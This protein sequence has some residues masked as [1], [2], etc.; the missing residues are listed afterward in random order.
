MTNDSTQAAHLTEA[1]AFWDREITEQFYKGWL[2]N[3]PIRIYANTLIGGDRPLWPIPWFEEW[4]GG[5]TFERGL[6]IGC[7]SG[8][9]ERGFVE[10]GLC[11]RVDAFDASVA[12]LHLARTAAAEA[13]LGDRLRYFAANFNQPVFRAKYDI[14]LFHQ[15]AHHVAKL[16]RL[17]RAVL[18]ALKPDGLVYMDE[19]VGPSRHEWS[20]EGFARHRAIY[21]SLPANVREVDVLPYP[22][23]VD[24]PSEAIRS[25]EIETQL[26]VGFR[27]VARRPYGGTLL[28]VLFPLLRE[29]AMT[30]ELVQQL[31]DEERRLLD[32]GAPSYYALIVAAPKRGAARLV[33]SAAYWLVPKVKRVFREIAMRLRRPSAERA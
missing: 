31:I 8:G 17:Y 28:S 21:D 26:C 20:E 11:Q 25:S 16:E 10:R 4:L 5:R 2:Q 33:A 1:R 7:G 15:S 24:D 29:E 14:V 27:T 22:I 23:M 13:G 6:S 12:S 30:A 3:L 32:A 19:Y 9:L 18:H